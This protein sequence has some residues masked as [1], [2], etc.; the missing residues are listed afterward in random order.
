LRKEGG[1]YPLNPSNINVLQ[2]NSFYISNRT[3]YLTRLLTSENDVLY[4]PHLTHSVDSSAPEQQATA[5]FCEHG[6]ET[7]DLLQE[8]EFLD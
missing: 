6:N 8:E 3:Q 2:D 7:S 4:V 1:I 5:R